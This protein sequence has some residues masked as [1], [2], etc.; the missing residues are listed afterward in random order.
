MRNTIPNC[1]TKVLRKQNLLIAAANTIF[2]MSKRSWE[3]IEKANNLN[4]EID[5]ATGKNQVLLSKALDD[6]GEIL[7][8]A[9]SLQMDLYEHIFTEHTDSIKDS[10]VGQMVKTL[11]GIQVPDGFQSNIVGPFDLNDDVVNADPDNTV[12]LLVEVAET[13]QAHA[14][15]HTTPG[16]TAAYQAWDEAAKAWKGVEQ[17]VLFLKRDKTAAGFYRANYEFCQNRAREA[18]VNA[19][20]LARQPM[21]DQ[22]NIPAS[23]R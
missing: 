11:F 10:P 14:S 6:L 21:G 22:P 1:V 2:A 8:E 12:D 23:D 3:E 17:A 5:L 15:D 20:T 9:Q 13:T 19:E 4:G 16:T 7:V 18:K